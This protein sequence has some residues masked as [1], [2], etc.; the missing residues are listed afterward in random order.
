MRY[1]LGTAGHPVAPL[2][3]PGAVRG[4][5][6]AALTALTGRGGAY[7]RPAPAGTG[8]RP[9]RPSEH[10]RRPGPRAR[11]RPPPGPHPAHGTTRTS[12]HPAHRPAPHPHHPHDRY[13]PQEPV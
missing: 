13:D 5:L 7:G 6:A 8:R 9:R 3:A 1:N 11:D 2:G 12:R 4:S 10:S